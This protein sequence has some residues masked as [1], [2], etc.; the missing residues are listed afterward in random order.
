[1]I[2]QAF[3]QLRKEV[4]VKPS[5]LE[6]EFKPRLGVNNAHR[7]QYFDSFNTALMD[8]IKEV[9]LEKGE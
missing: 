8:R 9:K 7:K 5:E 2:E 3:K 4:L 1:M 6:N